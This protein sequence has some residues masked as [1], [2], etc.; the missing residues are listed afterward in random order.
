MA[1]LCNEF[2]A[3]KWMINR[4]GFDNNPLFTI[5]GFDFV[6]DSGKLPGHIMVGK[7]QLFELGAMVVPGMMNRI[8]E[9]APQKC[10]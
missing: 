1:A 6:F 4:A 3:M 10:C 7:N 5:I 2:L 9:T 8:N